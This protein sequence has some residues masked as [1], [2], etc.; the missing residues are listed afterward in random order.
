MDKLIRSYQFIAI[1]TLLVLLSLLIPGCESKY[2]GLDLRA[3]QYRDTK[4]LVK[5]V[6]DASLRLKKDGLKSLQYFRDNSSFYLTPDRY[7]YVYDMKG[8]NVY[9]A[10]MP[11][12]V[13]KD[14]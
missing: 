2:K 8:V 7:L 12:L 10:G 4:D 5:F 11:H 9:H 14:L 13:G 1:S 3:Y 6:Y